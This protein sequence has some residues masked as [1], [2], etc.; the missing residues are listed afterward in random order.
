MTTF[1]ERERSYEKKFAMDEELRFKAEARR[2]KLVGQWAAAKLGLS[3]DAVE[4]YVK[5]VRKA[6]L[7]EKGDE[8][9]FRKIRKDFDEKGVAVPDAELHKQLH[10]LLATALAQL[11]QES[12][13]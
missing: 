1:D 11:E 3:G 13:K 8:D 6:D 5:A 4:D 2:N 7:A 12:K 10:D 9:V